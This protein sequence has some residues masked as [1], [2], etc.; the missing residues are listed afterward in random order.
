MV[1]TIDKI[2]QMRYNKEDVCLRHMPVTAKNQIYLN[3]KE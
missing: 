2:I 3:I 1:K